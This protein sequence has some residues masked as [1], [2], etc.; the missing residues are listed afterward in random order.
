[1]DEVGK[2]QWVAKK[3]DWCVVPDQVP[4][5]VLAIELHRKSAQVAVSIGAAAFNCDVRKTDGEFRLAAD[6][7]EDLRFGVLRHIVFKFEVAESASTF[8]VHDAFGYPLAIE[9]CVLL[10]KPRV[11]EQ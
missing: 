1:M 4:V 2:L 6:S 8:C 3:E 10:E 7:I 5:A 11:F 9:M